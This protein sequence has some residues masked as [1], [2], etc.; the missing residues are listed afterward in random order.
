MLNN[1]ERQAAK[2]FNMRAKQIMWRGILPQTDP[3]WHKT[4]DEIIEWTLDYQSSHQLRPD[5]KL[6]PS[7]LITWISEKFGAGI[8][9]AIIGGR[10]IPLENLRV[11][12]MFVPDKNVE[13][14]ANPDLACILSIP[15]LLYVCRDRMMKNARLR[16]H[17]SIDSS[18]GQHDQSLVIQWADPLSAVTFCPTQE[19]ADYPK[20][21]QCVGIELENV[22]IL[23]Q[24][25][26][27][28]RQWSKRRS[29]IKSEIGGKTITQPALYPSQI[30]ALSELLNI[31]NRE[32]GIPRTYPILSNHYRT[33]LMNAEELANYQGCLA[34]FNYFLVNNEPGAG[35]S[36]VIPA[37]FGEITSIEDEDL[38]PQT[39]AQ[40]FDHFQDLTSKFDEQREEL[41]NY[42]TTSST[43][44]TTH[45][46]IPKFNLSHAIAHA[47]QSGKSARAARI[48]SKAGRYSE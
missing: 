27:D 29:V 16:A 9:G 1:E 47:L 7:T 11:A 24:L 40:T 33:D 43:F 22:L 13:H 38:S 17:F 6:G 42:S 4:D 5:G 12:R 48:S 25:D 39:E 36:E 31:L 19:T 28:E 45:D 14:A 34:R 46:D 41:S 37:L 8:G 26:A 21:R 23:Y 15:E 18:C 3:L 30:R 44:V 2:Q 32:L 10:E 20:Q 35:F